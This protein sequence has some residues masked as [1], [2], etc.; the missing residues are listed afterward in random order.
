MIRTFIAIDLP[1]DV[2]DELLGM[3]HGVPGA[4]WVDDDQLHLTLRFVGDVDGAALR[5]LM[6]AL[7]RVEADAFELTLGGA[8]FFPP[9][10]PQ[11]VLWIGVERSAPLDALQRTVSGV[12][13]RLGHAPD[14]KKWA[15]HVTLARLDGAPS[16]RVAR[17]V[18]ER[19]LYRSRTFAV[20]A[21]HLYSSQLHPK[22]AI[23]TLE[24]SFPL[25]GG[26]A[27]EDDAD[28]W[29]D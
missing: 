7:S 4:R 20:D 12:A 16:N 25:V 19:A 24:E 18:A 22:G 15:P 1:E 21:F 29:D 2:R 14:R 23:Y 13:T 6:G 8:G 9:R 28:H 3:Q 11:R 27:F 5:D 17:F 10:G 26:A